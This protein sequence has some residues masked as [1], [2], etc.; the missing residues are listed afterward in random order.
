[1]FYSDALQ[2]PF[3]LVMHESMATISHLFTDLY[4]LIALCISPPLSVVLLVSV[5]LSLCL[6]DPASCQC[7]LL[8]CV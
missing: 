6:S 2:N 7:Q 1:M 4:Q 3:H 5:T 8:N